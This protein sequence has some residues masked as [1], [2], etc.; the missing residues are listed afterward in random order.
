MLAPSLSCIAAS[1]DESL[2]RRF[3]PV[4][5]A[6]AATSAATSAAS[7]ASAAAFNLAASR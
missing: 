3:I 2:G 1:A 6:T 4:A 5:A 7:A